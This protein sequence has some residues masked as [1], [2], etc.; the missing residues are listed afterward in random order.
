ML[1]NRCMAVAS[2]ETIRAPPVASA[3]VP[4]HREPARIRTCGVRHRAAR[5]VPFPVLHPIPRIPQ[6]VVQPREFGIATALSISCRSLPGRPLP[7]AVQANRRASSK[8]RCVASSISLRG[9]LRH[10]GSKNLVVRA[11]PHWYGFELGQRPVLLRL[12]PPQVPQFAE[13]FGMLA[14]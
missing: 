12:G 10:R 8:G 6:H 2:S 3:A 7:T 5:K 11:L 4:G 1:A 13:S 14:S 9:H